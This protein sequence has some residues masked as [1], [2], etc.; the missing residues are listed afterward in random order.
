MLP[1]PARQKATW[2]QRNVATPLAV[3][4]VTLSRRPTAEEEAMLWVLLLYLSCIV[5]QPSSAYVE[6]YYCG[7]HN[8]YERKSRRA[9]ENPQD[10]HSEIGTNVYVFFSPGSRSSPHCMRLL[11]SLG[12][13]QVHAATGVFR[14][15]RQE[16]SSAEGRC[17]GSP[18]GVGLCGF[19][20]GAEGGTPV[21]ICRTPS[22]AWTSPWRSLGAVFMYVFVFT[23][24]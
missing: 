17:A 5:L 3:D 22:L 16:G 7:E 19:P 11:A 15:P 4:A 8:C 9:G 14:G 6:D 12:K 23:H 1:L 20:W 24:R 10:F 13:S 18:V 2:Q 21:V